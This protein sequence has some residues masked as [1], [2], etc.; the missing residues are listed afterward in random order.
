MNPILAFSLIALL[1]LVL[2]VILLIRVDKLK[3][4]LKQEIEDRR[5]YGEY[6]T[7][8]ITGTS[9]LLCALLAHLGL[10]DEKGKIKITLKKIKTK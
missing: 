4:E 8:R 7:C 6:L 3:Q 2:H 10:K 5:S 9:S 1:F